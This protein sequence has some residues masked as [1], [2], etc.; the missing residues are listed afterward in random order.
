MITPFSLLRGLRNL[1]L[2]LLLGAVAAWHVG[3]LLPVLIVLVGYILYNTA[4]LVRMHHWLAAFPEQWEPPEARGN[5]GAMYDH[6]YRLLRKEH[7]ARNDLL[8]V[9]KRTESSLSALRDGVVVLNR[10]GQ[11]ETWNKAAAIL[12]GLRKASDAGQPF[13]DLVRHPEL[14]RYFKVAD[15]AEPLAIPSPY[16]T[17]KMLEFTITRFGLGE[18]LLLVRDVTRLH[19][20]EKMRKD[21]VANVSHELKTPLTVLKGYVETLQDVLP[22]EPAAWQR[23]LSQMEQQSVRMETLINDLLWLAKLEGTVH[24]ADHQPVPLAPLLASIQKELTLLAQS[25]QQQ[26]QIDFTSLPSVLLGNA[27]ELHSAFNNLLV[28]GLYYTQVAGE[29][30]VFWLQQEEGGCL[31]VADNGPGIAAHHLPRLTERFY[32]P[33]SGRV[34]GQGGTG[35]GLAI[36]KHV[37]LRH[38]GYLAIDSKV[39]EGSAFYCHFPT[40]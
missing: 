8:D 32:R 37:L 27:K 2:F 13:T 40:A 18:Y 29:V 9:L 4:Q 34:L 6:L 19:H 10:R 22:A 26:L 30:R 16:K 20:L 38:N 36:V 14:V 3:S 28:N 15:F 33:D 39:G 17:Q 35:L 7:V 5:W 11:L 24:G 23:A 1:V 21:F 25:K 31:V 12:L